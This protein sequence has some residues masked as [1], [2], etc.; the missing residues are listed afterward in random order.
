MSNEDRR[1]HDDGW[2]NKAIQEA[3][4]DLR[5]RVGEINQAYNPDDENL[6]F[7]PSLKA[8]VRLYSELLALARDGLARVITYEWYFSSHALYADGMFWYD[9]F[10]LISS[11]GVEAQRQRLAEQV[12]QDVVRGLVEVTVDIMR[13]SMVHLGDIVKRNHEALGNTLYGF[14]SPA[15]MDLARTRAAA[16]GSEPVIEAVEA[17]LSRVEEVR[18]GK[19]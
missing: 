17:T 1:D 8:N 5:A 12:P 16:S 10:L 7:V 13:F 19:N 2:G 11:A 6:H 3:F 18:Q 4:A 15:L 14:Y 9:L